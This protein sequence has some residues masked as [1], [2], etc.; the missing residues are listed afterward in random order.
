MSRGEE[1]RR[2][3]SV[4]QDVRALLETGDPL[5]RSQYVHLLGRVTALLVIAREDIPGA[6]DDG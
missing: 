4:E 6:P 3:Q 5:L 2:L 1:I